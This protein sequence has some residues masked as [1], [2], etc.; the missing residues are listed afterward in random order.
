MDA[1]TQLRLKDK[2]RRHFGDLLDE[3]MS[4]NCVPEII[5]ILTDLV[6]YMV[7]G[8]GGKKAAEAWLLDTL[9]VLREHLREH[10]LRQQAPL[11]L[12]RLRSLL[13]SLANG[14]GPPEALCEGCPSRDTCDHVGKPSQDQDHST[15]DK[16]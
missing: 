14:Q 16:T 1:D 4:E 2:V 12:Q 3:A 13:E 5:S 7:I 15:G 10:E 8:M 11:A 6:T 9:T